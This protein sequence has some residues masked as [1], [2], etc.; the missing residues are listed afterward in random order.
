MCPNPSADASVMTRVLL[1]TS[2]E[3]RRMFFP[4]AFFA[5]SNSSPIFS[6]T[7]KVTFFFRSFVCLLPR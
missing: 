6:V 1:V 7:V 4:I 5:A 3:F 2:N